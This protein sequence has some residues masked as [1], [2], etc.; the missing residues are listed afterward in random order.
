M[1]PF[2]ASPTSGDPIPRSLSSC[3]FTARR[4]TW[5]ELKF[6]ELSQPDDRG[7]PKIGDFSRRLF[8]SRTPALVAFCARR[9]RSLLERIEGFDG[10][11]GGV[12]RRVNVASWLVA[13][14]QR[15][16]LC[17]SPTSSMHNAEPRIAEGDGNRPFPCRSEG[18]HLVKELNSTRGLQVIFPC[19]DPDPSSLFARLLRRDEPCRRRHVGGLGC[20][21]HNWLDCNVRETRGGKSPYTTEPS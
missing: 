18:D 21:L 9:R 15:L 14:L 12:D 19:C 5:V 7:K 11:V 8:T 13:C 20:A 1:R 17:S 2:R 16:G 6:A 4:T 3:G 10:G